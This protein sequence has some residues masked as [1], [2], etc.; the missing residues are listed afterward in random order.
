MNQDTAKVRSDIVQARSRHAIAETAVAI[1][2]QA[3][4]AAQTTFKQ[5][6]PPASF[7]E[8]WKDVAIETAKARRILVNELISL[9]NIQ[10]E[11]IHGAAIM[12][13]KPSSR[14]RI[15]TAMGHLTHLVGIITYYLGIKLPFSLAD[16]DG[17]WFA[18]SSFPHHHGTKVPLFITE[19]GVLRSFLIGFTMLAYNIAYISHTQGVEI[20]D[21]ASILSNI[22][23]SSKGAMEQS[24]AT[25]YA[26]IQDRA[27]SLDF[28]KLLQRIYKGTI[29]SDSR[30]PPWNMS[31]YFNSE[32]DAIEEARERRRRKEDVQEEQEGWDMVEKAAPGAPSLA[33]SPSPTSSPS[34]V[35]NILTLVRR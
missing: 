23:K 29:K 25:A 20:D 30:S 7:A 17:Q 13:L 6:P 26:A 32:E 4:S 5:S 28:N 35:S 3:L 33:P 15:N 34:L 8:A 16:R 2:R 21:P 24:H 18:K 10:A 9:F 19:D 31:L 22:V 14:E 12:P 27:F 11:T 1:R